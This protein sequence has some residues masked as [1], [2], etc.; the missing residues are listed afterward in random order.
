MSQIDIQDLTFDFLMKTD[1]ISISNIYL[2]SM[3]K[4]YKN[5]SLYTETLLNIIELN[6]KLSSK[7]DNDEN[8]NKCKFLSDIIKIFKKF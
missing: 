7:E 3:E 5:K 2:P 8:R 4:V 1:N 6:N